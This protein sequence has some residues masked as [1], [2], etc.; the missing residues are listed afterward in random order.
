M[1]FC[2]HIYPHELRKKL[3]KKINSILWKKVSKAFLLSSGTEATEAALKLMKLY[4][5]KRKKR[6]NIIICIEG[7][8]HGRT[9]E[10]SL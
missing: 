2:I 10:L 6:K 4:G 7:N 8:W 5:I 3:Y 9:M 1:N